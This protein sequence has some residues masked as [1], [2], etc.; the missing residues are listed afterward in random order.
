MDL[1]HREP[2]LEELVRAFDA[3]SATAIGG[4][5]LATQVAQRMGLDANCQHARR[6][7]RM[8]KRC[9][10]K[11]VEQRERYTRLALAIICA[12]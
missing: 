6:L 12:N 4:L 11:T 1:D 7:Q 2:Y 3:S 9:G 10:R 5:I 8:E